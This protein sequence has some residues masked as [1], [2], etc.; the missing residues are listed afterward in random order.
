MLS[1]PAVA[2]CAR[3][4]RLEAT[5]LAVRYALEHAEKRSDGAPTSCELAE[6][7]L[8]PG[9]QQLGPFTLGLTLDSAGD[10]GLLEVAVCNRTAAPLHVAAVVFGFLWRGPARGSVRFLRHGWQSWSFTGGRAL[11][12]A[13]EPPFP[14]G[15]WLRGMHHVLAVPPPDRAGWHESHLV[16]VAADGEGHACLAGVL[17]R[18]LAT[19]LVYLRPDPKGVRIEVEVLL[20]VPLAPGASIE[21]EVVRVALGDDADRLLEEHALA[22]GAAAGARTEARFQ[23]GWCSWYQFFHDVREVDL[24]RNLEAL[25]KQRAR[26]PVDVVQLDDGYQR[27]VG[28]WLETNEKFPR[29]I[30]SLAAEIRAA[31]FRPGIWT[32]PF[33][34]APESR[35]FGGR[36]E[37][38]LRTADGFHRGLI[39][40]AWSK[41]A[42]IYVL[43]TSRDEVCDHL[44]R[45]FAALVGMGFT[46]LKLDFLYSAAMQAMAADP[47][48]TR[49]GRL[50]RGLEAM[51]RGAGDEAFLLGC[52][53]PLG[54]AVGLVDGM[55]IGP[56]VA[57]T[58][59]PDPRY[60]IPGV[61]PTVPSTAN[62]VRNVLARAWM[63]RRLWLN[64]PDCLMARTGDTGLT[65]DEVNTLASV[66]TASGGMVV[67]SDDLPSLG[68]ADV[69]RLGQVI[70]LAREVDA[71]GAHG[72]ARAIGLLEGASAE[73][74]AG[75]TASGALV[76]LV[77]AGDGQRRVDLTLDAIVAATS[78]LPPEPLLGTRGSESR[79]PGRVALTL[80]PHETALLRVH[81]R[82]HLAVFCDFDGTFAVQDV[83]SS[84]AKRYAAERRAVLWEGLERGELSAWEYNM[85]LLDGLALPEEQLDAFLRSVELDPGARALVAWCEE[86][87]V[88]FRVLSDGFDRNLERLQALHGV[89]FAYDANQ[90]WYEGGAWRIAAGYP[91]PACSCGTGTCKLSRIR[92]FRASHPGTKIVHVGNGRVS[93]LCACRGAD[94]VFAKDTLAEELHRQGV[95]FEPFETLHDVVAG[96]TRLERKLFEDLPPSQ[97]E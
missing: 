78:G 47:S 85:E 15:P 86:H 88:P 48:V 76:A 20:E 58:W 31:G 71:A 74:L 77:N 36:P 44:M 84:I 73:G 8:R 91:D 56:D 69:A 9:S 40:P 97:G 50:R 4:G 89:R 60:R 94:V 27:A 49:A 62:A 10:S 57:P 43:D 28:D 23:S 68:E 17:E 65:H 13:G 18:G 35:L 95:G 55:R 34:V 22:L 92:D 53:C 24:L 75:R 32:A 46:Y 6:V 51:R 41:D 37:W 67:F 54:P 82:P 72:T 59:H 33:C 14:S 45:V 66:I 11:D 26:L 38:L 3:A 81:A 16:S 83:G 64:D 42:S 63:H 2:H 61:E 79:D 93:D 96:L 29:G 21:P 25:T 87:A 90:L 39:H 7:P 12:E 52:G 1:T 5:R 19:G 80:G 70:A 30:A